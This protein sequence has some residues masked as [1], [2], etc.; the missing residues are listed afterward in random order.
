MSQVLIFVGALAVML[1]VVPL[2]GFAVTGS[3]KHALR[4]ARAWGTSI[5]I[6]VAAGMLLGLLIWPFM[7]TR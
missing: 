4:Y 7:P 6:L 3:W 1:A 5:A 2:A